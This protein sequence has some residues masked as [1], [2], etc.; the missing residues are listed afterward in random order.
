MIPKIKENFLIK[1]LYDLGKNKI[2]IGNMNTKIEE[3]DI[4]YGENLCETLKNNF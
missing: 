4:N 3:F 1:N 2:S